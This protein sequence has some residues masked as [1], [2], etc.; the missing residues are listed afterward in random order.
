MLLAV[1]P[2]W[3]NRCPMTPSS[4]CSAPTT[5]RPEPVNSG[6]AARAGN[7]QE[8]RIT[9]APAAMTTPRRWCAREYPVAAA[10]RGGAGDV[11]G[12]DGLGH[13]GPVRPGRGAER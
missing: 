12:T 2:R 5:D 11:P 6:T 1:R 10:Q 3:I 13:L 9:A 8:Q 7:P 4:P